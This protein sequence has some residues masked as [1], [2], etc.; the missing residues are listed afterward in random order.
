MGYVPRQR[1]LTSARVRL[2]SGALMFDRVSEVLPLAV[3]PIRYTG[4]EYNALVREAGPGTV[5]WVLAMPDVYEIGMSNYGLRVLYSIINRIDGAACDRVYCPWPDFGKLL[6]ERGLE[7]YSLEHK[8][9][10]RE[11]DIVG[12]TLQSE[13]SCTNA[14]YVLDLAKIPLRREE[15]SE[16][17][18]LVIAGGPCTVNPLPFERFFDAL[19]VGDGEEVVRD[20]TAAYVAWDKRNRDDLL[21][22]LARI[23]GV[24]VPGKSASVKRRAVSELRESDFPFPPLVA[25]CEIT[26]DRLTIEMCRGCVRGCRFCQAGMINRPLRYRGV[27]EIVRLAERGIRSSGWEEVSLL[28]LS[29]LDYPDLLHLVQR[30]NSVLSE[31]R[32]SVSLPSTR[33]EEFSPELALNLQEVKKSGLTFAPETASSR[34]KAVVNK[35]IPEAATLE[36]VRTALDAGWGGVKLYFMVGLPTETDSDV[37]EITRFIDE[38]GRTC[39]GR[40][41]RYNLS[42]FVP[43]PHT[44]LQWYG[45]EGIAQV[46]AKID[47]VRSRLTRRNLKPKWENPESSFV[48]ALLARGDERLSEVIEQVYRAGGVFQEWT[49][50][51]RL[52]R[53]MNACQEAGI[54][55]NE[56]TGPRA[57]DKPLA[58][59]KVDVGVTKEFLRSEYEKTRT[60]EE[61][62]DCLHHSCTNCGACFEGLKANQPKPTPALLTAYAGRKLTFPGYVEPKTRFRV[63]YAV[64]EQYRYAAHLDRVRAWYR[65][66]RRSGLPIAFSKGFSPKPVLSFGPPLPVGLLSESEYCDVYMTGY[67]SGDLR[68]DLGLFMPKGLAIIASRAISR[69]LSTLGKLVNLGRYRV[70]TAAP[71]GLVERA[72]TTAG[73]RAV[74]A[75]ENEFVMDLALVA[76]VRLM[77][78]LGQ[79]LGIEE[80]QARLLK[81]TRIDCLIE[82]DNSITSPMEGL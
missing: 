13:L 58:W 78:V 17:D 35:N 38:V 21:S 73:V 24:Y 14:L 63:R 19:V 34:L 68:K 76:G 53:W 47:R 10:V 28:A 60:G 40:Q 61:T 64:E 50:Y 33:G 9:P 70:E 15:R 57:A 6:S 59:D 32:V 2:A 29:A 69:D 72:K 1:R 37:D 51:F 45:F 31:R 67:H 25:V 80:S 79:L 22:V 43:K 16:S 3:K 44:P 49:E 55:P 65:A 11:F 7:L 20:I 30:L 8:R 74:Q 42:P 54:D 4:G 71:A 52:D 82:Q 77:S 81:V 48:Q 66:L 5:K 23:G 62:P 12:I 27:D 56:Y 41:V 18:P 39:R 26:H 46:Q 36:A 75:E